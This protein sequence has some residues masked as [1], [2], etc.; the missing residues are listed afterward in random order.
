[1]SGLEPALPYSW[2]KSLTALPANQKHTLWVVC[3]TPYRYSTDGLSTYELSIDE[4]I[5][6][7]PGTDGLSFVMFQKECYPTNLFTIWGFQ[8]PSLDIPEL[9]KIHR[10]P[11]LEAL[12]LWKCSSGIM[13]SLW[14]GVKTFLHLNY[15]SNFWES[16]PFLVYLSVLSSLGLSPPEST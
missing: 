16:R 9:H 3:W 10:F 6:N 15:F 12:K 14:N 4:H 11:D 7:G 1:M 5:A 2:D 8:N 13:D